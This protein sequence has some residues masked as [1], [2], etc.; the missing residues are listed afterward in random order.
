M[1]LNRED[2]AQHL[3]KLLVGRSLCDPIILAIP[4][5][6]IVI[7][8]VLARELHAEL[9]VILAR[10]LRCPGHP[11]LALGAVSETG[12]VYLNPSADDILV[13]RQDYLASE[14]Q[15]QL[16]E[17]AR[18]Q[19]VFRDVRPAASLAGR[20]VI[21]TDDGVATGATM[22]SALQSV[23]TQHPRELIVAV[24]VASKEAARE[25]SRWADEVLC[26]LFAEHLYSV[27]QFYVDCEPV[28]DEVAVQLLR[29]ALRSRDS[30]QVPVHSDAPGAAP[31][32]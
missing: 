4:R 21:V 26:V 15:H 20:S 14:R 25:L 17:I 9:D 19:C 27:G 22:I 28:E 6:G 11:E 32:T 29:R 10:K 3:A 18:R 30:A 7:G 1:F 5:G 23:R 12:A 13:E 2:G 8:A 16:E 24:P 31:E